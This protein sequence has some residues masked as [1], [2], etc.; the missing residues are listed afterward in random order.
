[1]SSSSCST[2]GPLPTAPASSRGAWAALRPARMRSRRSGCAARSARSPLVGEAPSTGCE[3]L[4]L[5]SAAASVRVAPLAS[6]GV[7]RPG[8]TMPRLVA[9]PEP[10][11]RWPPLLLASPYQR[12]ALR[13][14]GLTSLTVARRKRSWIP[15]PAAARSAGV[16]RHV[17]WSELSRPPSVSATSS[18]VR[19]RSAAVASSGEWNTTTADESSIHSACF[20][21]APSTP[22]RT[23][24]RSSSSVDSRSVP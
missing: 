23:K 4:A 11:A 6:P 17:R 3:P 1:M 18:S 5:A 14:A 21:E 15:L 2:T 22:A 9:R 8:L 7:G 24:R 10:T 13:R 12:E 19:E 16:V 20:G